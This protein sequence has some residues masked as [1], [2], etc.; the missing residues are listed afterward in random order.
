MLQQNSHSKLCICSIIIVVLYVPNIH[1]KYNDI[2]SKQLILFLNYTTKINK[3]IN[4]Y[5]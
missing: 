2:T 5:N 4:Y 1:I 3:L